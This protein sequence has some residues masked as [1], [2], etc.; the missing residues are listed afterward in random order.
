MNLILPNEQSNLN[1]NPFLGQ[2]I[3]FI[4]LTLPIICYSWWMENSSWKGTLGKRLLQLKIISKKNSA[5]SLLLRN[6][7]KYLPWE[8]AHFGVHWLFYYISLNKTIPL[9]NWIMLILPQM[10]VILY[11]VSI[12]NSGGTKSAYDAISFSKII[13]ARIEYAIK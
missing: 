11:F 7:L 3:G 10:I 6:I 13:D 9:W 5:Q 2:F 4:S 8:L 1:L 12:W